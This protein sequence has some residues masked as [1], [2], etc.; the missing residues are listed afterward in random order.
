M[1]E[2]VLPQLIAQYRPA[3]IHAFNSTVAFDIVERFGISLSESAGLF[4]SSFAID[5]DA[6]GERL[7]VM[8][9][10]RPGFLDPVSRVIVDS[11]HYVDSMVHEF[12]YAREKFAIQGHVID[13]PFRK[14]ELPKQFD[15]DRPL[16]I[17]WAGRFDLPK[18]LDVLA[19]IAEAA[20]RE[21]LPV[22]FAFY[23]G[24][25]M[26]HPGLAEVL[27]RLEK[28]GAVRHPPYSGFSSLPHEAFD[29]YLMTS[30]WEGVPH[31]VLEAMA[32]GLPVIAPLVGGVGEVLDAET[33]YPVARFDDV[34]G[35]LA[36]LRDVISDPTATR[37]RASRARELID[38]DFSKARFERTLAEL[39]G[40]LRR[41]AERVS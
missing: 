20:R 7:S 21:A 18:R 6:E 11:R 3:T 32:A 37:D 14:R 19:A 23:G 34:S 2:R 30:E 10:R 33:G 17:L 29:V 9:L 13:L 8:F 12:G 41:R 25:V 5:R 35:Y 36:A 4:L 39:P 16:R 28:A 31:T 26:G 27:G 24:E 15:H 1:V 40:Y 38:Q 22:E